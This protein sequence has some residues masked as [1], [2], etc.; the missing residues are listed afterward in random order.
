M[1]LHSLKPE[2]FVIPHELQALRE[3]PE[4]NGQF[5]YGNGFMSLA[6]Y[7]VIATGE[8]QQGLA[9]FCSTTCLLRWEHPGMMGLVQ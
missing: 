7:R 1:M 3:C 8:I 6:H 2:H 4:C 9:C 5:R